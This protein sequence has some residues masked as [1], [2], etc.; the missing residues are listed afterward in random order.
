MQLQ[1]QCTAFSPARAIP[2]SNSADPLVQSL[3][4]VP[5]RPHAAMGMRSPVD[6]RRSSCSSSGS[7]VCSARAPLVT[8]AVRQVYVDVDS[9][10]EETF[11]VEDVPTCNQATS[12]CLKGRSGL[13]RAL[14]MSPAPDS[15]LSSSC[16]SS[17]STTHVTSRSL[18]FT[19]AS[20][21]RAHSTRSVASADGEEAMLLRR[22]LNDDTDVH[23][24]RCAHCKCVYSGPEGDGDGFSMRHMFCSGECYITAFAM[25][26]TRRQAERQ[27]RQEQRQRFQYEMDATTASAMRR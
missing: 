7:S 14:A 20:P 27:R 8:K 3:E 23:F 11:S 18:D 1:E 6:D 5:F 16:S 15:M 13:A 9:D 19:S 26:R 22:I 2:R 17:P 21:V 24:K 4:Q 25:L 10:V 12:P